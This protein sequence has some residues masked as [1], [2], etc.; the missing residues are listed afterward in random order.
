MKQSWKFA[1]FPLIFLWLSGALWA[2][3]L[4]TRA[5][6]SDYTETTRYA[7]VIDFL[8]NLQTKS[9]EIRVLPLTKS[10][11]GRTIPLV[12]LGSPVPSSPK[13]LRRLGKPAIYIQ[14]NIHA[15]EVEGKEAVLMLI[16]EILLGKSHHLLDNQ[17]LLITPIYN[18]DGNEKISKTNRTNQHGPKGGVGVRYNGQHLDLN[19]DYIKLESPENLAAVEKILNFWDPMLLMDLH[20][21][22]GSYH[23]EP[24]TYATAH[25]PNGDTRLPAYLREKLFPHVSRVLE[26]EYGILSIPYGFFRDSTDPGKGWGT[27]GHQ[28]YYG[29]NYWGLRNRFSI[30]D[31]N[32]AYADFKTR[33]QACY[34]FVEQILEFTNKHTEE[35]VRMVA[36]ADAKTVAYGTSPDTSKK[37]GTEFKAVAF[38]KPILIRGYDFEI[39]KDKRGRQRAKKLDSRHDYTVPF[40]GDFT[41]TKAI[42]LAKGYLFPAYLKEIAAKLSEHGILVEKLTQSVKISVEAFRVKKAE[43]SK[44]M[45]QGHLP[46]TLQGEYEKSEVEF[47]EGTYFVGMDQPLA[48]L[49]A[50]LLEPTSDSGLVFW[51]FFD[52]YLYISQWGRQFGE[53]PVYRLL[54]PTPLAKMVTNGQ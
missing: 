35:M 26:K 51:N 53:F 42:P 29:T 34:H 2:G 3:E 43:H 17:V 5:E 21:T 40:Y 33:V 10:T 32:Y 20:T 22:N 18:P 38:E 52:R 16:R 27:Y 28:P 11:E 14:A 7:E 39:Y 47:P 48:N 13:E 25:N 15:G 41:V 44:R 37:F 54:E 4:L 23:I 36:D 9:S 24:L 1:I 31:E 12:I 45:F 19:R 8:K 6:K 50:Y 49:A 46:T 30:L